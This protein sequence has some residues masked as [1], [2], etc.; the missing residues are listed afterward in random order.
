MAHDIMIK[1]E[2]REAKGNSLVDFLATAELRRGDDI[3]PCEV[4]FYEVRGN[5]IPAYAFIKEGI[6]AKGNHYCSETIE[7]DFWNDF[8]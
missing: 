3:I 5:M 2:M 7:I 4:G 1:G 8:R 6:T